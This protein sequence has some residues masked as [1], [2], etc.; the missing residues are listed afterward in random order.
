MTH[1]ARLLMPLLVLGLM[2]GCASDGPPPG[3]VRLEPDDAV[4]KDEAP[5]RYGNRPYQVKGVWYTPVQSAKGHQEKGLASWYGKQFHGRLTSN[6]EEYDMYKMTAAH[7][8]LPLPSYVRVTNLKNGKS[9]VVRVNDRGPFHS[10]RVIDL[11]YA[12]AHKLGIDV[13]GVGQVAVQ[14]ITAADVV[15][16]KPGEELADAAPKNLPP[17]PEPKKLLPLIN[18][19]P[20]ANAERAAAAATSPA[21]PTSSSTAHPIYI[22]IGAYSQR[23][24]AESL[25]RTLERDYKVLTAITPTRSPNGLTLHR[26]RLGPVSDVDE[27]DLLMQRLSEANLGR[28][29]LVLE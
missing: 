11:S 27:A 28:P 15:N 4:P 14:G 3:P 7:K 5:S 16:R 22:Q 29:L 13:A 6:R 9:A 19:G 20:Y 26:V 8:T 1:T 2:A 17:P 21:S 25:A 23:A 18:P 12:A 24:S 10:G